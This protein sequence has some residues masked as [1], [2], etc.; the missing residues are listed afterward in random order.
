MVL[1]NVFQNWT[2][3]PQRRGGHWDQVA[4]VHLDLVEHHPRLHCKLEEPGKEEQ[5]KEEVQSFEKREPVQ[6]SAAQK[7]EWELIRLEIVEM[8][9]EVGGWASLEIAIR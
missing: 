6:N 5:K 4:E 9:Q 2:L 8:K 7:R 3:G 1:D